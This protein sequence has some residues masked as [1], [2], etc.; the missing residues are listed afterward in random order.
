MQRDDAR[1][2][3]AGRQDDR[4]R[5]ALDDGRHAEAQQKPDDG[6]VR[7]FAH[8]FFQRAGRAVL[9]SV[10]HDAHAVEEQRQSA[11]QCDHMKN[12]H[13]LLPSSQRGRAA[14]SDSHNLIL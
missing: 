11:E 9:Q 2:D 14:A 5:G 7:H 4:R 3:K 12:T 10:A 13:I 8:R 1:A 6:A